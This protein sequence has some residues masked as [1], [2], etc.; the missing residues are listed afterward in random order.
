MT[1]S[2]ILCQVLKPRDICAVLQNTVANL[3]KTIEN[4]SS[5]GNHLNHGLAT[6]NWVIFHGFT[7]Q[8]SDVTCLV[9]EK[10]ANSTW[11]FA[12]SHDI[13]RF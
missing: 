11:Y 6:Y 1:L 12:Q 5:Q 8:I 3:S 2:V 4:A 9:L 7:I 10:F 13:T